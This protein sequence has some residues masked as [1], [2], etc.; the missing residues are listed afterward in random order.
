VSGPETTWSK[1]DSKYKAA[2]REHI[3]QERENLRTQVRD[4]ATDLKDLDMIGLPRF[5]PRDRAREAK[6]LQQG[7]RGQNS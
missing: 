6:R 4:L 1:Q 3:I 2:A 5:L 7:D